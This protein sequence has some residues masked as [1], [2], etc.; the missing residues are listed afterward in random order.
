MDFGD[1]CRRHPLHA[2]SLVEVV[3]HQ[4]GDGELNPKSWVKG[5][6]GDEN[7]GPAH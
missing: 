6:P 7:L 5:L 2:P 1:S 4:P 3:G